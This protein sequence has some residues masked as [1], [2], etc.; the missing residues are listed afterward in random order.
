M[1]KET[2]WLR[3]MFCQWFLPV[4]KSKENTV[5]IIE[6]LKNDIENAV[7]HFVKQ[8]GSLSQERQSN[9]GQIWEIFRGANPI[10]I[11]EELIN[12]VENLSTGLTTLWPFLEV[13]KFKNVL[14]EVINLPRYSET[15]ILKALIAE[16]GHSSLDQP[17]Q[18]MTDSKLLA[19]L[20][21]LEKVMTF[22]GHEI[23]ALQNEISRLK[24]ENQ[25]L[26]K[27]ISLLSEK[28]KQLTHDCQKL[29]EAKSKAEQDANK[30]RVDYEQLQK[31]NIVLKKQL[32]SLTN[33]PSSLE[34]PKQTS[35]VES[36]RSNPQVSLKKQFSSCKVE[37]TSDYLLLEKLD[38]SGKQGYR[39]SLSLMT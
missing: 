2:K 5:P 14:R 29:Q 7:A 38:E 39:R 24:T 33:Q 16:G 32:Q 4:N 3:E 11:R 37:S 21:R 35:P 25:H 31:E 30:L 13:N 18:A 6:R 12:I 22:Q 26:T 34:V 8:N 10:T 17:P 9:L 36:P 20:D 19:R 1:K 27:T 23:S 15:G 28:N